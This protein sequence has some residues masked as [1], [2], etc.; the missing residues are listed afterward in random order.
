MLGGGSE[1]GRRGGRDGRVM[2]R[3]REGGS[4]SQDGVEDGGEGEGAICWGGGTPMG[5]GAPPG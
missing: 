4:G 5:R 2:S 1:R 3:T